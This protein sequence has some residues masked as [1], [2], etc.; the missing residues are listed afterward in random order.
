MNQKLAI[1]REL[2][3]LYIKVNP[4]LIQDVLTCVDRSELSELIGYRGTLINKVATA[5]GIK[6]DGN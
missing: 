6:K 2:T 3:R 4:E 5:A 1:H